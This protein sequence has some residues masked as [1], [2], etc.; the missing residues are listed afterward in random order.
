MSSNEIGL[1]DLLNALHKLPWQ[2][3]TQQKAIFHALGFSWQEIDPLSPQQPRPNASA[4]FN[5][6]QKK[7][8]STP[9]KDINKRAAEP[10]K[11]SPKI[12][13]P[14]TLRQSQLTTIE[15]DTDTDTALSQITKPSWLVSPPEQKPLTY[16]S[17][18]EY[19][20]PRATLFPALTQR[21]VIA[22]AISVQKLGKTI[23]LPALIVNLVKGHVPKKLP[24]HKTKSLEDGCRLLLD[25]SDSMTPFWEDLFSLIQQFENLLNNERLTCYQFEDDPNASECIRANSHQETWYSKPK[26]PIVV[27]TDFGITGQKKRNTLSPAWRKFIKACKNQHIPLVILIPWPPEF[28]PCDL[29]QYPLLISWS[30]NTTAAM[31]SRLVGKGHE[32]VL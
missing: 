29:D 7:Q 6:Y 4:G 5:S 24:Y 23:D 15:P 1:A 19:K 20:L 21:G 32:L 28:W 8:A 17:H 10:P 16:L 2:N 13:L 12:E 31:V 27:A 11:P 3:E 22:A 30:Q 26:R 25:Y 14:N 18:P 9:S